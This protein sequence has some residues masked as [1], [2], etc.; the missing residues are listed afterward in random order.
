M[1]ALPS[2]G[3]PLSGAR[4]Y[5]N[6][7]AKNADEMNAPSVNLNEPAGAFAGTQPPIETDP[8]K[9]MRPPRGR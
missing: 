6:S 7:A 2:F 3:E 8:T 5:G 1:T 4:R 9:R